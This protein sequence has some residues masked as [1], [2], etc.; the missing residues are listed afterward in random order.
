MELCTDSDTSADSEDMSKAQEKALEFLKTAKAFQ[1]GFLP[2]EQSHPLSLDLSNLAKTDLKKALRVLKRIDQEALEKASSKLSQVEELFFAIKEARVKGG[3]IFLCGCGAT[4]RLALSLEALWRESHPD[5]DEVIAFMAG[6]DVAL[7]HSLEGFE[8]YPEYGARQL[9]ELKFAKDDLLIS[10][11]EGGET[12]FVIGATLEAAKISNLKPFFLF[13]NPKDLLQTHIERSRRVFENSQVR[14]LSFP[15]GPMAL[16]GSTRMQASTV[17]MLVMGCALFSPNVEVAHEL[18]YK[19]VNL[20]KTS[21]NLFLEQFIKKESELYQNPAQVLYASDSFA[22]TVLTDTTERAP[23][24]NLAPFNNANVSSSEP[25]WCYVMLPNSQNPKDSWARLL[26]RAPR[27]LNWDVNKKTSDDYLLGFDFSRQAEAWRR[28]FS[29]QLEIFSIEQTA[30]TLRWKLTDLEVAIPL[31]DE[32]LLNHLGLKLLLNQLSTLIMGRMG[33]FEG[34]LMTWLN[35]T[36]G[37]LVDRSVRYVQYLCQRQGVEVSYENAVMT[38][39]EEIEQLK[40]KESVVI[41]TA[42]RF[43]RIP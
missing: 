26:K 34:N 3:R 20:Q 4:G 15:I 16:A 37:K 29:P 22:L 27:N 35:P 9:R 23:T 17:L 12:P 11:T 42:R 19:F 6:G 10:A 31:S 41:N 2:T 43:V 32:P 24:F 30:K 25:S 33:R 40:S 1:L 18:F 36:N 38:L 7:V 28:T 39:F 13:C 14:S 21:D 8:D 5:S